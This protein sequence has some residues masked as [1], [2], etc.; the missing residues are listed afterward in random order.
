MLGWFATAI[1]STH[2]IR[3]SG[4]GGGSVA[5]IDDG[6][7]LRVG[8]HSAG[9]VPG[10]ASYGTGGIHP[11]VTDAAVVLGYIDPEFF[12]G[13]RIPLDSVAADRVVGDLAAKLG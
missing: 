2:E 6:G 5:W 1:S 11:T 13:G 8:P 12:A 3:G 10:P 4:A 9:S 7:L